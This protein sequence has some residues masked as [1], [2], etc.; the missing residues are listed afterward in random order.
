MSFNDIMNKILPP[1]EGTASHVTG[2]YGETR[3]RKPLLK[4]NDMYWSEITNS[5]HTYF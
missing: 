1:Q 5:Q 2:N 3:P 4:N